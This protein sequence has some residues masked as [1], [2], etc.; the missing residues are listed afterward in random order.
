MLTL[1]MIDCE[2]PRTAQACVIFDVIAAIVHGKSSCAEQ[3]P[4]NAFVS[5]QA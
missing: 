4:R 3:F 1:L 2:H 5:R